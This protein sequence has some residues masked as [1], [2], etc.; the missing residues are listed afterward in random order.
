M[1]RSAYVQDERYSA[2][3]G[4]PK[5]AYVQ[6]E[7]WCLNFHFLVNYMRVIVIFLLS[8][9][10][11]GAWYL[12]PEQSLLANNTHSTG[13]PQELGSINAD[14]NIKAAQNSINIDLE[15]TSLKGTDIDG[16]YPVDE[17]GN[18][19]FSKSIKYRF[20]YFLSTI[21]EFPLEQVLQMV[22]DDIELNLSDPAKK[23][24]LSLFEDYIAYKYALSE[25]EGSF[26]A[27]ESYEIRDTQQLR[28]QLQQLRDKRREYLSNDAVD[29]FFGFDE[30][31]D[32]YVLTSLEI[33]QSHQLSALEK[34]QQLKSLHLSLPSEVQ[35]MRDETTRISHVFQLTQEM[36]AEG[37]NQQD[38]FDYNSQQF[39][40]QAAERLKVLDEHRQA[41]QQKVQAYLINK[42]EVLD[43][44]D[45]SDTQKNEK[46]EQLKNSQFSHKEKNRLPAFEIMLKD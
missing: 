12:I 17:Q 18:L 30:L 28:F 4:M 41:W 34:E 29:A 11:L 13:G 24:A 9:S 16:L 7:R 33:K 42:Q 43:Q 10:A 22:R 31:Y 37:A 27:S 39:G 15:K 46:I 19:M 2:V 26:V 35:E 38:I 32:D 3:A 45:L 14:K 23:Q 8:V 20:E 25:L 6:D 40:Q 21:G 44:E 1:A 5:S 36:K